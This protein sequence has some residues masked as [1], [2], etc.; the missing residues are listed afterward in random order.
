MKLPLHNVERFI[1][2]FEEVVS[3]S[4]LPDQLIPKVEIDTEVPLNFISFK[5]LSVIN[6]MAPF[7]PQNLAPLFG[8]KNVVVDSV[9]KTLKD[10]H[11]KGFLRDAGSK[12][13]YEFIGFGMADHLSNIRVGEPFQIAYHLEENNYRGNRTIQLILK[14]IRFDA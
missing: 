12:K 13:K 7:G 10:K 1:T 2:K 8:T 5:S 9:P 4:I 6:Q 14:D 11:I 3:K